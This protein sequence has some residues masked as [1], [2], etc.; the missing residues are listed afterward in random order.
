ML[1]LSRVALGMVFLFSVACSSSPPPRSQ[2]SPLL[3]DVMPAF[4]SKTLN[5]N[6]LYSAAF[7]GGPFVVTFVAPDCRAC[8]STLAAAQEAYVDLRDVV[9]VGVFR[10]GDAE[11][12]S[13]LVSKLELRFPVVLDT[14]EQISKKFKIQEVPKTFV[15]DPNG[16]VSWI[17][18][19]GLTDD[20]LKSAVHATD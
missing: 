12:A 19:V 13:S 1:R 4:E 17:G 14:D 3:G 11:V 20:M 6:D 9:V 5:G 2:P 7:H 15:I 10:E 18:G 16:R 8:E